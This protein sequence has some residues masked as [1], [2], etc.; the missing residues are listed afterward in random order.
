VSAFLS[1][2]GLLCCLQAFGS[3]NE[4]GA[5]AKLGQSEWLAEKSGSGGEGPPLYQ[6]VSTGE[7]PPYVQLFSV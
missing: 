2:V 1:R 7:M 4:L 5:V 6:R 3:M